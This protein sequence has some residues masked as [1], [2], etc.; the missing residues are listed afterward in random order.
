MFKIII[1]LVISFFSAFLSWKAIDASGT[2]GVKFLYIAA[3]FAA[4][5]GAAKF[6]AYDVS[7]QVLFLIAYAAAECS[8]FVSLLTAK[9]V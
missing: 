9:H 3:I 6:I 2:V 8:V 1:T 7:L 5:Y 4:M